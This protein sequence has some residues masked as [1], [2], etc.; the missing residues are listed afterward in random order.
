MVGGAGGCV[1][2][3][4]DAVSE[5]DADGDDEGRVRLAVWHADGGGVRVCGRCS[6]RRRG[7]NMRWGAITEYCHAGKFCAPPEIRGGLASG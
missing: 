4:L 5:A 3:S 2:A 1:L 6:G 7:R